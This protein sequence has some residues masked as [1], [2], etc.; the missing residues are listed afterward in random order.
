[1]KILIAT[2]IFPPE[3]GGPATYVPRIAKEFLDRDH[4]V[5]VITYSDT[6][7]HERDVHYPFLVKRIKRVNTLW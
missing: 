1:M 2:G 5:S 3:I 7:V 4:F 6:Y